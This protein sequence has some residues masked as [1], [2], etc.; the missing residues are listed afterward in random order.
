M[1][2]HRY[3][4]SPLLHAARPRWTAVL[5]LMAAA[6]T[7]L[8]GVAVAAPSQQAP[9]TGWIRIGHLAP[10][11]PAVDV[12]LAEFGQPEQPAFQ[13]IGYGDVTDFSA[14]RPGSY[15]VSM[16][17]E[18][19]APTA[20][21]VFSASVELVPGQ[22][23]T[24]MVFESGPNGTI[25]PKLLIDDF[26]APPPASARIRLVQ[27]ANNG[28]VSVNVVGGPELAAALP[29]GEATDFTVVPSGEWTLRLQDG[30]TQSEAVLDVADGAVNTV[31]ITS[32][33]G[34]LV[35]MPLQDGVGT[36]GTAPT[37]GVP[38]GGGGTAGEDSNAVLPFAAGLLALVFGAT[39]WTSSRRSS[40]V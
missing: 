6:M 11:T 7:I 27:G 24:A 23:Y 15:T 5:A 33:P 30:A 14:L 4:T 20:A 9:P 38:T 28:P 3:A 19:W 36:A 39:A 29:Y 34:G 22:S 35:L 2:R 40:R 32:T 26:T 13:G 21:P 37:G 31:V 17:L 12:Y 8:A 18:G 16:R 1:A 10:S 25:Q